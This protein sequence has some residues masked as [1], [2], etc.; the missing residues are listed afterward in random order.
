MPSIR[1]KGQAVI[2][3]RKAATLAQM[4]LGNGLVFDDGTLRNTLD[5]TS[6]NRKSIVSTVLNDKS[7]MFRICLVKLSNVVCNVEISDDFGLWLAKDGT[8]KIQIPIP[9]QHYYNATLE[10]PF[11]SFFMRTFNIGAVTRDHLKGLI[12]DYV[13]NNQ[14]CCSCT[15]LNRLMLLLYELEITYVPINDNGDILHTA[16]PLILDQHADLCPLF[17]TRAM[18]RAIA[19]LNRPH[20]EQISFQPA[21]IY[22]FRVDASCVQMLINW[23]AD[24]ITDTDEIATIRF[25]SISKVTVS[26]LLEWLLVCRQSLR[27]N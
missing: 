7:T 15:N 22:D 12:E 23:L 9:T 10:D 13:D 2:A 11:R 6:E 17:K 26:H 19:D 1:K 21:L 25:P 18:N 5:L 4:L 24:Q 3:R 16:A 14:K 27:R 20:H 8:M